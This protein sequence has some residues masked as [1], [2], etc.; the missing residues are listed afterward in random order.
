MREIVDKVGDPTNF[1]FR[2]RPNASMLKNGPGQERLSRH[3]DC[4]HRPKRCFPHT[5][6]PAGPVVM[7][8]LE[9]LINKRMTLTSEG[10][11]DGLHSNVSAQITSIYF[12]LNFCDEKA[13]VLRRLALIAYAI[14]NQMPLF[15]SVHTISTF[16]RCSA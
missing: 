10:R 13:T 7:I 11:A 9:L 8:S 14:G 12:F 15:E 3:D 4:Y 2:S 6:L 1:A 16:M 5:K